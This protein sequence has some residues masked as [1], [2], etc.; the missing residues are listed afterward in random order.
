[1]YFSF[2][3]PEPAAVNRNE[4]L[5]LNLNLNENENINVNAP[6]EEVPEEMTEEPV[7]SADPAAPSNDGAEPTADLP[8]LEENQV[9]VYYLN[10]VA[11]VEEGEEYIPLVRTKDDP[12]EADEVFIL[13]QLYWGQL[14][15]EEKEQHG[16]SLTVEKSGTTGFRRVETRNR[17][18]H[19]YLTGE[20]DSGGSTLTIANIIFKNLKALDHLDYVKIYDQNEETEEPEGLSD[21]IPFCLEP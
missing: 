5:N 6:V 20:C 17:V 13:K 8:P 14:T 10:L 15:D 2:L 16:G 1:L 7:G 9:Y 12:A 11:F 4:N 19:V 3:K 21:S 18:S